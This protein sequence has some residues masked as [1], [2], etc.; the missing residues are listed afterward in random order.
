M[1]SKDRRTEIRWIT[2]VFSSYSGHIGPGDRTVPGRSRFMKLT[3]TSFCPPPTLKKLLESCRSTICLY[4]Y[5]HVPAFIASSCSLNVLLVHFP[6][7][8]KVRSHRI[9]KDAF[10]SLNQ[11]RETLSGTWKQIRKINEPT[12]PCCQLGSLRT[13]LKTVLLPGKKPSNK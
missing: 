3:S 2:W 10:Q 4:V 1:M 11:I 8:M 5:M 7:L 12:F 6:V 13:R 9:L